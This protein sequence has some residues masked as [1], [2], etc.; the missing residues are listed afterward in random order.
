MFKIPDFSVADIFYWLFLG[1]IL[2]NLLQ[3]RHRAKAEKKRLATLF[4]AIGLLIL[5]SGILTIETYTLSGWFYL[6][7]VGA[8]CT[9]MYLLRKRILVFRFK[10]PETGKM[11]P[12]SSILFRDIDYTEDKKE[13]QE[14]SPPSE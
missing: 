6:L 3:R 7:V 11:L 14:P 2:V 9:L 5:Y 12:L 8:A 1:I 4:I 13:G 10:D